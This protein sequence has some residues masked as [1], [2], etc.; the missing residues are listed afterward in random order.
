M[1]Y[2]VT[3][4]VEFSKDTWC[5]K[6]PYRYIMVLFI[7]KYMYLVVCITVYVPGGLDSST[8]LCVFYGSGALCCTRQYM[9]LV[10]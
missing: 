2:T 7:L 3:G 8:V 1:Y 10:V 4:G 6:M 9:Y 5:C